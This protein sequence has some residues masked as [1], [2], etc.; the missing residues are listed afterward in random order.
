MDSLKACANAFVLLILVAAVASAERLPL[1][2]FTTAEGLAHNSVNRVVRDSRGFLWLCTADGLSRFDGYV[3]TNYAD[4][5]GLPHRAVNDLLETRDHQYWIATNGGLVQMATIPGRRFIAV[6]IE[7]ADP[8]ARVTRVLHEGRDG[9]IWIGTSKGLYRLDRSAGLRPRP[10]D[11]GIPRDYPEQS[12]VSDLAETSDGTLWIAT[13]SGL[14][15]RRRD[16]TAARFTKRDGLPD[17][18]LHDLLEDH[19]GRLWIA[20]RYGG[21]FS[22]AP[23][24]SRDG[25]ISVLEWYSSR[26][27]LPSNWVFQMFE[28][29]DGQFWLGTSE[30][31]AQF[32]ARGDSRAVFHNY[33]TR[34]GLTFHDITAVNEDTNSNLWI[35]TNAAGVLK[36]TRN[37]FTTYDASDGI[38]SV[39][40]I[41]EDRSGMLCFRGGASI[42]AAEPKSPG[43]PAEGSHPQYVTRYGRFDGRQFEWF[44]PEAIGPAANL[45]WVM[46]RVTLQAHDGEW[47]LGT[48][49]GV[50]RFAQ[51]ANFARIRH[52]QPLVH[53]STAD[54]LPAPQVFRLFE[55]TQGNIWTATISSAANG[56]A[57]WDRATGAWQ[58]LSGLPEL[59]RKDDQARA[60]GEDASGAIWIGFNQGL[61]RYRQGRF[62]F[63]TAADGLPPG[64][65]LDIH[66]DQAKRLWLASSRSGL[67]EVHDSSPER[68][69]FS[70]YATA[71]GLSSN[72]AEVITDD[73]YGRIY[74]AT[75][76]A[77]DRLDPASGH[78]KHFTTAD[79]VAP[80]IISAAYRDRTGALWFGTTGGLSR[81][82]PATES[83][84]VPPPIFLTG[85]AVDGAPR[86]VSSW[87]DDD[88]QLSDLSPTENQLQIG[89]VGLGFAPGESLTY[90]YKLEGADA[91]WHVT[92]ER[93]VNYARLSPG[94]YRFVVRA[95]NADGD[96]SRVPAAATFTIL[97]PVWQRWWFDLA[98]A[99]VVAV[100]GLSFYRSRMARI[101]EVSNVRARIALD[102][103]DDIGSNLTKIAILSEVARQ[104]LAGADAA[105][106]GPLASIAQISRESIAGMGDIVWAINPH[107]DRLVELVRR[108]RQ[109]AEQVLT[110]VGIK[111]TFVT[112]NEDREV[113]FGVDVRRGLF[114][115]FKEAVNNVS[116][117]ARCSAVTIDLR[118]VG[119]A[120]SLTVT[121]DGTGFDPDAPRD[122]NGL[123]SM[124][125]RAEQL[126]GTCDVRA[127]VGRGTTV[128]AVIPL[129]RRR[130][131]RLREQV[132]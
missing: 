128:H 95:I 119:S 112:P 107:R 71:Q 78:V 24:D 43:R 85:L 120:L 1:R 96:V 84:A 48:A 79:G 110:V 86:A 40:A 101:L 109:H 20:T 32:V 60:F 25:R 56:L 103:H 30:G 89:F 19:E 55:D 130:R 127:A 10:V 4:E 31:L 99:A 123:T 35:G 17:D 122:G 22:V 50:F 27:G 102:L 6:S 11:I 18:Y 8:L 74:V 100:A 42:D 9:T 5:D 93:L 58:D 37:G 131:P 91:D 77:L 73:A 90:Q 2:S 7:D 70:A 12:I 117:H 14:Y 49:L 46:E 115:I 87:G 81:L 59:P 111:V 16:G 72:R 15:H 51:E 65:I 132:G 105:A 45:G 69:A 106:H 83:N 57:R 124:R 98:I 76:R 94:H 28:T 68:P 66:L 126:G 61:A 36:L 33:G 116:R 34:H 52:A 44:K 108:M 64:A 39:N 97:P 21:F 80:G 104:R 118:P 88:I 54:G 67:V 41:F 3:F 121:D 53:Y 47:W 82:M 75:G 29:S 113:R 63:F 114:L 125:R 92:R 13:P 129:R 62:A 38:G 26:E 23:S